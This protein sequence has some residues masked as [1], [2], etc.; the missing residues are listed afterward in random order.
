MLP[1]AAR[2]AGSTRRGSTVLKTHEFIHQELRRLHGLLQRGMVDLTPE[3]WNAIP[4]EASNSIGWNLWHY[5]RT[6]DNIVRFLLQNRRPTVWMEGG[7]ADK[8]GLPAV[9][10]GTGMTSDEAHGIQITDVD[11][12]QRYLDEVWASTD[13]FLSNPDESAFDEVITVRPLGEMPKIRA[14]GQV[15]ASHG[16]GHAGHVDLLRQMMDKPGLGI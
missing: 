3:E 6:E 14:L 4:C 8:L 5:G 12:F 11:T 16:Y 2:A 15:C 7:Y 10:Q 13:E 9:A 1:S